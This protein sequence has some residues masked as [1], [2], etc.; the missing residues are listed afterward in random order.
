MHSHENA[1]EF[2]KLAKDLTGHSLSG[3]FDVTTRWPRFF[4]KKTVRATVMKFG[5][6]LNKIYERMA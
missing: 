2:P 5:Q 6:L 1:K 3:V 4:E